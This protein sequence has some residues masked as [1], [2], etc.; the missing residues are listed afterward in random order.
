MGIR[1]NMAV[2]A[3]T[4]KAGTL[5]EPLLEGEDDEESSYDDESSTYSSPTKSIEIKATPLQKLK[6]I[7]V[8]LGLMAGEAA[9]VVAIILDPEIMVYVMAG[10]TMLNGL[11][12]CFKEYHIMKNSSLRI[13][14]KKLRE[15]A[16]Q[17]EDEVDILAEEIELLEPEAQRA[18][19]VE[20]ELNLIADEQKC[21]VD[22]LVALVKENESILALM[23]DNLRQRIVQDTLKIV[24]LSD[25]N[26]D[27]K[28]CKV[29]LKMLTLKIRMQ[30]SEYGVDFEE[31][32]FYYLMSENPTV[33]RAVHILKRL[34]P[35][36]ND[37][38]CEDS[39]EYEDEDNEDEDEDG[40]LYDIFFINESGTSMSEWSAQKRVSLQLPKPSQERR[41]SHIS[42][43]RKTLSNKSLATREPPKT[44][45]QNF[46]SLSE[47]APSAR[48]RRRDRLKTVLKR[49]RD[50][51]PP[52]PLAFPPDDPRPGDKS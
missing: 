37:E 30:L 21:N 2:H 47:E 39:E 35:S 7:L 25:R 52:P 5:L 44:T 45:V 32:K 8:T 34:I 13:F 16:K 24:M 23:R 46:P 1:E 48:M 43:E 33:E 12:S 10:I 17:L 22:E 27:G 41:L 18:S 28:F 14:I 9:S 38:E 29:E 15:D 20:E 6:F 11:L 40:D 50:L 51:P 3:V 26:N 49:G 19:I 36:N 4:E 42:T 31:Q